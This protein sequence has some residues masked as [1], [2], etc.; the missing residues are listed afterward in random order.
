MPQLLEN[1]VLPHSANKIFELVLDIE[2]YP[3]FLPWCVGAKII[4]KISKNQVHAEL[5]IEFK[6]LK[7]KYLSDVSW[8]IFEA[9]GKKHYS[10]EAVA[11]RGPFKSL[12]NRWNIKEVSKNVCEVEF[13]LNFEFNS[14]LLNKLIGRIF[15]NAS[16]KMMSAF[17]ERAKNLS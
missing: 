8:R 11:I 3:Q 5:V 17:E 16:Q 2:N 13:F 9:E 10:I 6:G 1:R 15:L 7:E 12:V 4:K 14:G